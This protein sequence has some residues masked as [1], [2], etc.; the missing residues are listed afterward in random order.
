MKRSFLTIVLVS[1]G[2]LAGCSSRYRSHIQDITAPPKWPCFR[3]DSSGK[4]AVADATFPGKLEIVW[5]YHSGD[6]A[7]G[8]LTIYYDHLVYPGARNKIKFIDLES[9]VRTGLIKPR[10]QAQSGFVAR[11][12]LAFF[13]TG[14]RDN[15]LKCVD[16]GQSKKMW[17][18]PVVDVAAGILVID[19]TLIVGSGLGRL[20][21]LNVY[22]GKELWS[23][24]AERKLSA[25]PAFA[26]GILYQ[27]GDKGVLFALDALDGKEKYRVQL[28]GPL[29]SSATVGDKVYISDMYGNVYALDP[30]DGH[31]L[32]RQELAGPIWTSPAL[33]DGMLYIGHSGGEVV[34]LDAGS[35]EIVWSYKTVDVVRASPIVVGN[36]VIAAT[37]TGK[38]YSLSTFDGSVIDEHDLKDAISVAPVT[39]GARVYVATDRGNI[40]CFGAPL[41]SD[42]T[43]N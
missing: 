33:S 27:P 43:D 28:D 39:D 2:L 4:G 24:S 36:Y 15:T 37:L 42:S 35:G 22:D 13:A 26:G 5:E 40:V 6:K 9:G 10:G 23:F 19:K 7:A 31:E 16:I 34:A 20:L 1:I 25:P 14:P 11:K 29:V 41:L 3:G 21:A 17:T 32:W 8:P 30:L 38:V 12:N 18:R